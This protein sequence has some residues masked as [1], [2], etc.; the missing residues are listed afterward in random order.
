MNAR[1]VGLISSLV[2]L[3]L[4]GGAI[5]TRGGASVPPAQPVVVSDFGTSRNGAI[6]DVAIGQLY[7][8]DQ[9]V[10]IALKDTSAG[11]V[12]EIRFGGSDRNRR[13][14][15]VYDQDLVVTAKVP[16]GTVK[17]VSESSY[18][19]LEGIVYDNS[20]NFRVKALANSR[21]GQMVTDRSFKGGQVRGRR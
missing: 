7:E 1:T 8:L 20:T 16:V 9:P 10:G 5:F 15:Y 17:W 2:F 21:P 11:R 3:G 4:V 19:E 12:Y 13:P 6:T 18:R 14:Q